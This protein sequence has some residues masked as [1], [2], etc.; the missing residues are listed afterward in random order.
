MIEW[1]LFLQVCGFCPDGWAVTSSGCK[2]CPGESVV[3]P[4]RTAAIAIS[5]LCCTILWYYFSWRPMMTNP[6]E[7]NQVGLEDVQSRVQIVKDALQFLSNNS[8]SILPYLKLFITFFQVLSS[9]ITF[10]VVWPS[11]LLNIMS[12]LKGTLF[13]DV[14]TL[15]GLSCLWRGVS[16]QSRLVSYTLGPL[17]GIAL[18]LVPVL[19]NKM[20]VKFWSR[21]YEK[22]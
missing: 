17:A 5:V 13:L 12:W 4:F 21:S 14:V 20:I 22:N 10:Q 15:P 19:V 11:F 16:F 18:L 7:Q 9:F 8:Q 6:N 3:A 2:S 1:F